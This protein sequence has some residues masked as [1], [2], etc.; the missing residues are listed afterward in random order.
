MR[1]LFAVVFSELLLGGGII[2]D[3]VDE[4][5]LDSC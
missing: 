3:V 5:F 1:L 4:V 2:V